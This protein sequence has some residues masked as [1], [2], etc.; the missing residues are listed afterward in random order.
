VGTDAEGWV[1]DAGVGGRRLAVGGAAAGFL[2]SLANL[3]LGIV[4]GSVFGARPLLALL[5]D[6]QLVSLLLTLAIIA[7]ATFLHSAIGATRSAARDRRLKA[8]LE[9]VYAE[10]AAVFDAI[11]ERA[12]TVLTD[13]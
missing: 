1:D 9:R 6:V 2:V 12:A 13:A 7:A 10:D 4:I 11:R 3:L 5:P 8:E